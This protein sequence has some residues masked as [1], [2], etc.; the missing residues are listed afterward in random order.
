MAISRFGLIFLICAAA[1]LATASIA[2]AQTLGAL[3]AMLDMP[4]GRITSVA[5]LGQ[6]KITVVTFWLTSCSPSKRQLEAMRTMV[7]ELSDSVQFIAVSIDPAKTVARVAPYIASKGINMTVL[8]DTDHD[9]FNLI[10]GSEHP[11][12]LL[13]AADGTLTAKHVGYYHGDELQL[14][15]EIAALTGTSA[16]E[17]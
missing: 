13:F 6:G 16:N 9:L 10:N 15:A 3:T 8:L 2:A 11:Y 14:R 12:T 5:E 7:D 4:G 1:T 17:H